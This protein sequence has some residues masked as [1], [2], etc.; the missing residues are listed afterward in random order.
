MDPIESI[1]EGAGGASEEA[2]EGQAQPVE[3]S[4]GLFSGL[5]ERLGALLRPD[6]RTPDLYVGKPI[7]GLINDRLGAESEEAQLGESVNLCIDVVGGLGGDLPPAAWLGWSV[8][9]FGWLKRRRR[10]RE[11]EPV[12]KV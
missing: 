3:G 8:F 9:K 1:K 11:A 5:G 10:A 7:A 6:P 2:L 12:V 4:P